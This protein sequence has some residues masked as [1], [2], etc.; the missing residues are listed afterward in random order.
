MSFR[1]LAAVALSLFAAGGADAQPMKKGGRGQEGYMPLYRQA[2][3]LDAAG[4]RA[5][6][7]AVWQQRLDAG[8]AVAQFEV[9]TLMQRYPASPEDGARAL[10][11]LRKA[12][13]AGVPRAQ[14]RLGHFYRNGFPPHLA[15]DP[16]QAAA[17]FRR[18][19][20]QNLPGGMVQLGLAYANGIGVPRDPRAAFDLFQRVAGFDHPFGHLSLGA[21]YEAGIGVP[22]NLERAAAAYK[23]A[24]ERASFMQTNP[25]I[26]YTQRRPHVKWEADARAAL[27]GVEAQRAQ[28]AAEDERR[29]AQ[30]RREAE[31]ARQAEEARRLEAERSRIAEERRRV[32]AE[33]ARLAEE[34]HRRAGQH[35]QAEAARLAEETRR[36]EAERARI[37]EERRRL[38]AENTRLAEQRARAEEARLAEERR[39]LQQE[40]ERL[41]EERRRAEARAAAERA[42]STASPAA[43]VREGAENDFASAFGGFLKGLA[44]AAQVV[45]GTTMAVGGMRASDD[46]R[47]NQ[48]VEMLMAAAGLRGLSGASSGAP[49]GATGSP[50]A[51]RD[52]R[53]VSREECIA[54]WTRA[55]Q[56]MLEVVRQSD[57]S[58]ANLVDARVTAPPPRPDALCFRDSTYKPEQREFQDVNAL[59]NRCGVLQANCVIH[60]VSG[61]AQCAE[62]MQTCA[63][64]YPVPMLR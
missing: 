22:V 16:A 24:I 61:G 34:E 49:P 28:I 9:S 19:A 6:A 45:A 63:S 11:L 58:A 12:A 18:A 52:P 23:R 62:A 50:S 20:D 31:A 55:R 59:M 4:D 35:K 47:M 60:R 14:L 43:V 25:S 53:S 57:A 39:R 48:G 26:P 54:D 27:S 30:E 10:D 37:A 33:R 44:T 2:E 29:R 17:W 7:I 64:Q 21:A 40:N 1:F 38:E 46:A 41:A 3:P 51:A 32:D 56:D 42:A 15:P 8:D 5:R 13:E 36:L